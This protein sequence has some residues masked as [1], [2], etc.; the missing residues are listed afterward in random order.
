MKTSKNKKTRFSPEDYDWVKKQIA[1]HHPKGIS[2]KE[3]LQISLNEGKKLLH[4][5]RSE[6]P[7]GRDKIKQIIKE[8]V[9][10]DWVYQKSKGGRGNRS[11]LLPKKLDPIVILEKTVHMIA[12]SELLSTIKKLKKDVKFE[13]R[14]YFEFVQA[15]N[16]LLS[17][18]MQVY[19]GKTEKGLK[20]NVMF[21]SVVSAVKKQIEV[22]KKIEKFQASLNRNFPEIIKN[23]DRLSDSNVIEGI[24]IGTLLDQNH[25]SSKNALQRLFKVK[26]R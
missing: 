16:E 12:F 4:G 25:K 22:L 13:K 14:D 10:I 8:G 6:K 5:L 24:I 11:I 23:I 26:K 18:P 7:P 17:Y 20:K 21:E 9:G 15:R 3:L 2:P 1:Y 19:Y